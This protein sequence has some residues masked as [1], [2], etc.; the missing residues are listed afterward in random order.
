VINGILRRS[1]GFV[2]AIRGAAGEERKGDDSETG[3]DDFF[4][5]GMVGLMVNEQP[6]MTPFSA[7]RHGV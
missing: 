7:P 6:M 5:K 4:H 1:G 3:S 2:G